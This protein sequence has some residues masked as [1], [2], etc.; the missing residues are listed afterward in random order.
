MYL[1]RDD[2]P[3]SQPAI[4]AYDKPGFQPYAR[5]AKPKTRLAREIEHV[6]IG[7]K[8]RR[9]WPMTWLEFVT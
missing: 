2:C 9:K 3:Y 7:C 6:L 8:R 4:Y 1:Q 5:N